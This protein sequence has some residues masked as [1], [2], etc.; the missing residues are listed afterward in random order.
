MFD[1]KKVEIQ[2]GGKTL[3][4]ETGKVARQADGAV[5]ATLGETVVLCAVTAA[6][7]VKEG[8][9]FFPLT[10][11]YQEKFSASGRIPGGFFKRER[12]ATERETLVS[13]LI[14]RPIRPLFPEGF[15][16]E[17]NCIAQVMSYDGENEP[18]LLA[19]IAASAAMT[20]S[21]VPFMGPIG[22]ARVG[23]QD[24]EYILNPSDAQVVEGELDLM[25]AAT[26]DAVMMVESEAKELSEDV[27]LGAVMF[28]HKASQDIINAIIDLAEQAAKEPWELKVQADSAAV[29]TKLKKLIGKDLEAAYKLTD[30][31]ARQTAI[32]A[33]RTKARDGMADLKDSDPQAYLA[34]LKLV[35]KLEAEIVRTAI[36]KT[37]RRI[38]G[39]DTKTVRPIE[40]EVHFLPRAHGSAL[41]TRG[42]T[43]TIA[44]T[45]LGTR[46][47]EQM[48]DGLNGLSYQHFMLHYNF[49]PYSVGE[50]GRF[51]APGRREIG[52]GKLAWRALHPVLPSKEEF[53]YTI[54]VTSDITES[55]GS[56]SMAT[57][58]GGSLSLMDAGVPLKRPVSGIAMGLILEGKDYAILSDILGDEDHLGDM[59][60]KV[61]GTSEGITTMQMDIKIAGITKEIFEAALNQAK[62]GR[63]HI[64]GEMNKALGEVRAELSAH[65]PRIETFTIDKSKIREVIGTGGKVIR[66]IVATTGAKVDID[67]EGVIKV[68]SSDPAQIEAAIK[69]IKGLVE[70][71]EVGKIYNG[72]VVNLV[73]FG[74]FVNFMGG[75]DGLV[76][77]SEIKNERVEKVSDV[78][79]EGQEVK[80]KVLEIDPRGKVR[81]SMRV[82]D[83]ETGAELED[84]RPAREP[85]ERSDRGGDR[86]PRR[87][88]GSRDGGGRGGDR[89]GDR[90]GPRREGRGPR[91]ER[92]EGGKDEGDA[93]AFAPA[94]LTNDRD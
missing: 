80:V 91:R 4:L 83:Q 13:R 61:A 32:N 3:T 49:P 33:A 42:E 58:C 36:L 39:R 73:D 14:D 8:Q 53:P 85:R 77:V 63:A 15:Y 87:D 16:N 24:G 93:P 21:G 78:L 31:Q 48:I 55:N 2:W 35:K 43:Q 74:A 27:M 89:G 44:T 70:E 38:D 7:T 9:D 26:H 50:V 94:F 56:S 76:H 92:G 84:T 69:W 34:S 75:K 79:S 86:G 52:H 65:A 41:F 71:A 29:K 82:V 30:K 64:L 47:A 81:L 60:F 68:S 20:L 72:K 54:R 12:G 5:I 28:A 62:A 11:H 88:G 10:V 6:K 90:G 17:I 22:A 59:D 51:G 19:M 66:E 45:T 25:V 23:Y 46:D 37:G 57:V 67:D 40:A 18:D 1:T